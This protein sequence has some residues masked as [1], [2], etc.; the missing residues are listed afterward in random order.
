MKHHTCDVKGCAKKA[1][2]D[3]CDITLKLWPLSTPD[4][5]SYAGCHLRLIPDLC[6]EHL[7]DLVDR[8]TNFMGT[9]D[10]CS[11]IEA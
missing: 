3:I 2:A 11:F 10:L 4:G 9:E 7:Q 6:D 5:K 8:L 1:N